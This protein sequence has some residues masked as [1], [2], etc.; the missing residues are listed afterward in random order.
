MPYGGVNGT[1]EALDM[2]VPV[3]TLVGRRHAERTSYS[4][5]TQPRRHRD[6]RAN[7]RA[8]TSTSPCASRPIRRSCKR[9]ARA[10]RD[11][12][13]AF[14]ADR[15]GGAH[16]QSR[17]RVPG[18]ARASARAECARRCRT[19]RRLSAADAALARARAWLAAGDIAAARTLCAP[20]VATGNPRRGRRCTSGAVRLRRACG[21]RGVGTRARASRR[22]TPTPTTHS[23]ITH[24]R[25]SRS[26][27]AIAM[28]RSRISQR[29]IAL[30]PRFVAAH[31]RLGILH[32]ERG[33]AEQAAA[34]VPPRRRSS[35]RRNARA[36]NNLGNALR[37][38]GRADEALA[39]FERAV[40]L[41]PDYELAIANVAVM[42]RDAG[43]RSSARRRCCARSSRVRAASRRCARSSSCSPAC[44]ASV[45]RSTRPSRCIAR[46]S[47]WRRRQVPAN[48]SISDASM[49][50]ATMPSC[51]RDAYRHAFDLDPQDLRGAL[52]PRAVAA[53]DL[54]RRGD[55]LAHA[56]APHSR[57]GCASSHRASRTRWWQALT[58]DQ[59][60]DGLR[61][62]NFF[63][64]YQGGNDRDLQASYGA[65]AARD[66]RARRAANGMRPSPRAIAGRSACASDS[67]RRSSTS[68]R[69]AA[70]FAAG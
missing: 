28:P 21:R 53:D 4:I 38:L 32:G 49:P 15:H 56:R 61:W 20:L 31:Q 43:R 1:L 14:G 67:R 52:A 44:C 35:I 34:C 59:V 70:T 7:R 19:K 54:R 48:G 26:A 45:A 62:T 22:C 37:T 57:Q 58:P 25:S 27:P 8:S 30:Q 5:L 23:R 17:A 46:R 60:L 33:D 41:R 6:D 64:A 65:L 69:R 24:G 40:A 42:W 39:A 13:R 3:V 18:C 29:A 36:F 50:S 10:L 55:H 47:R 9:F 11:A 16:A 51:A 63:L 12:L 68:A 2:G 66:D